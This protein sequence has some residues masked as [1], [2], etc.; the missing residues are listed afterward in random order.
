MP[1]QGNKCQHKQNFSLSNT[2]HFNFNKNKKR[3]V[4]EKLSKDKALALHQASGHLYVPGI[5][6]ECQDCLATKGGRTGHSTHRDPNLNPGLPLQQLNLD[7]YGKLEPSY[8]NNVFCLVIIC[9]ISKFVWVLPIKAKDSVVEI[10]RNLITGLRSSDG[11]TQC[12]KVVRSIRCDNEPV[13]RSEEFSKM[14]TSLGVQETHSVP[15][16][17]SQSPHKSFNNSVLRRC[18]RYAMSFLYSQTC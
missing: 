12:D 15:Y 14:L 4:V 7:F 10:V 17:P 9:D 2:K 11:V 3:V 5:N 16:A 18:I 8:D 13:L 1:L 6:V